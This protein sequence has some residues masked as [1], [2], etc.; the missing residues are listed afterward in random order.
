MYIP[1]LVYTFSVRGTVERKYHLHFSVD[2]MT[3]IRSSFMQLKITSLSAN[4]VNVI[5][6][7]ISGDVIA[8]KQ[9]PSGKQSAEM[10]LNIPYSIFPFVHF[11][12]AQLSNGG[13][14]YVNGQKSLNVTPTVERVP[15]PLFIS[16]KGEFTFILKRINLKRLYA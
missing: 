4:E 11:I 5:V 7:N 15:I 3:I 2:D 6:R 16:N 13:V 14:L 12:E 9:I 1:L 8:K 10:E